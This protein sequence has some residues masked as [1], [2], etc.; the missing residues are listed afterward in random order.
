M[1]WET[2]E[3]DYTKEGNAFF[4]YF[5]T[6]LKTLRKTPPRI[7]S[8]SSSHLSPLYA[9]LI[10]SHILNL[11]SLPLIFRCTYFPSQISSRSYVLINQSSALLST[12]DSPIES[13][14]DSYS[15][16]LC[17][18]SNKPPSTNFEKVIMSPVCSRE[19]VAYGMY[20]T[21]GHISSASEYGQTCMIKDQ[22]T[23][24]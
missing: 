19:D 7:F 12:D 15:T 20:D 17:L 3:N 1:K 4:N 11:S 14:I 23:F 2:S 6:N 9:R 16:K 13:E 10:W 5:T 24:C 18:F 8:E 21:T 22:K